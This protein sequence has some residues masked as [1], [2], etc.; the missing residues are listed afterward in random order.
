MLKR[1]MHLLVFINI[2][3]AA[4]TFSLLYFTGRKIQEY[5]LTIYSYAPALQEL[6]S[7]LSE[8][9]SLTDMGTLNEAMGIIN[10][11]YKM[12]FIATLVSIIIFFLVWCFFQSMEWRMAYNSLKKKLNLEG[13]FDRSYLKYALNFS[14][15]T[16]PAFI[17][18]FPSFYY[19]VA[20]AKALFLNLL[21]KLYG[22][23]EIPGEVSY[24]LI[25]TLFLIIFFVSYFTIITYVLLNR[26]KLLDAIKKSFKTGINKAYVLMPLHLACLIAIL[27]VIYL[28]SYLMKFFDFKISAITSLLVYFVLLAFYQALMTSLLEK[29]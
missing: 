9:V 5:V 19:F 4:T 10:Q 8:D 6:E 16:I 14:L 29:S 20:Q 21:I 2:I 24:T 15:V 23:T 1:S 17:I 18:L 26:Y 13:L 7:I 25:A 27:P 22:L 12:I 28:D 3:F 11:F